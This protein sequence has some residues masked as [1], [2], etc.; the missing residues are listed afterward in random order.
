MISCSPTKHSTLAPVEEGKLRL[1]RSHAVR[2]LRCALSS[3]VRNILAALLLVLRRDIL[4][5]R[6]VEILAAQVRVSRRGEHGEHAVLDLKQGHVE[7][8]PPRS[9]TRMFCMLLTSAPAS[10]A[11]FHPTRRA[12]AAAVAR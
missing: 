8:P 4:R 9:N 11:F 6:R 10:A 2:S 12:R 3:P 5:E 7:V 1:V